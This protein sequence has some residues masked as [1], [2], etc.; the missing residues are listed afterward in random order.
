M[1]SR[2]PEPGLGWNDVL[3][4]HAGNPSNPRTTGEPVE[5]L[6]EDFRV[7]SCEARLKAQFEEWVIKGA[8]ASFKMIEVEDGP[9]E[10]AKYRSAF[11]ADRGAGHYTWNGR[12]CRSARNDY[13]GM[14]YLFY[15]LLKRCHPDMTEKKAET[16]FRDNPRECG[17]AL[18]WAQGNEE[19]PPQDET[20]PPVKTIHVTMKEKKEA[21]PVRQATME[22]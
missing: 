17:E 13:P 11:M 22:D 9:E 3:G 6:G 19:T 1:A 7:S 10:A 5:A 8:K 15:L 20:G 21:K 2:P 16:I 14:I 18:G 12:H 4:A